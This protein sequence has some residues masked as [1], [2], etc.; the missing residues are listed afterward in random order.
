M[1][2]MRPSQGE[3]HSGIKSAVRERQ[4][5]LFNRSPFDRPP[6][7]AALVDLVGLQDDDGRPVVWVCLDETGVLCGATALLSTMPYGTWTGDELLEPALL[8]TNTWTHPSTRSDRLGMLIAHWAVGY[9]ADHGKTALRCLLPF[10]LMI[11]YREH[12]WAWQGSIPDGHPVLHML[13]RRV[14]QA[15]P[16]LDKLISRPGSPPAPAVT[17][18]TPPVPGTST[19]PTQA[20]PPRDVPPPEGDFPTAENQAGIPPPTGPLDRTWRGHLGEPPMER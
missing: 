18:V 2:T 5:W 3:D 20:A 9:A 6:D 13:T 1:Y 16:G 12:G 15:L 19:L 11:R 17:A 8:L 10:P 7:P 4:H 14:E